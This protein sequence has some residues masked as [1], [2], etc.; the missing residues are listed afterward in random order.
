VKF[1]VDL[2]IS[3]AVKL[4]TAITKADPVRDGQG[5]DADRDPGADGHRP[6]DDP[7]LR[8]PDAVH[9]QLDVCDP[10]DKGSARIVLATVLSSAVTANA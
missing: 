2:D 1:S 4:T 10:R 8:L 9:V 6:G 3:E 7:S 5:S